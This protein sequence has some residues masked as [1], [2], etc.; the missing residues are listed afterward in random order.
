ALDAI[1]SYAIVDNVHHGLPTEVRMGDRTV[2]LQPDAFLISVKSP[3][4]FS[5]VEDEGI[6]AALR[7]ELTDDLLNEGRVREL[8]RH[9]Q[10]T[11]KKKGLEI[12]DRIRLRIDAVPQLRRAI[13]AHHDYIA[14]E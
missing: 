5:A 6:V 9:V 3:E 10:E 4:G 14:D 7:T 8:V 2:S 11:R 1:D 12:T 13:D